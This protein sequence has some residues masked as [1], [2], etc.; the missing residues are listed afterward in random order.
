MV[1]LSYFVYKFL[2]LML[3]AVAGLI[4]VSC[5]TSSYVNPFTKVL[6]KLNT[7]SKS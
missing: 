4:T 5:S 3:N 1:Y 7:K 2:T 6:V